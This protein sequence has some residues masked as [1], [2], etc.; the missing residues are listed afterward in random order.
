MKSSEISPGLLKICFAV[1]DITLEKL[2]LN[3]SGVGELEIM[4]DFHSEKCE[5]GMKD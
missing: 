1:S 5:K 2:H 3:L 4:G